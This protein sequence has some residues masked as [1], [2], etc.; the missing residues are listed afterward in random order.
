MPESH[1]IPQNFLARARGR[2]R[3]FTWGGDW[4]FP[5]P[6]EVKHNLY[7][8]FLDGLF[9]T[10]GDNIYI[11]YLAIYILAL[12]ATR[13][14]IGWMS[15]I[16]NL[17][18]ALVLLPGALLVERIG[19]RKTIVVTAGGIVARMAM[20]SLALLPLLLHDRALVWTAIGLAVLRDAGAN[21]AF[22]AWIAMTGDIVPIEGRGRYFGSRNVV[23]G[24]VGMLVIFLAGAWITGAGSP[25]GYQVAFL[26]AFG[27]GSIATYSYWRL[28][29]PHHTP[30]AA[31]LR[32][33]PGE[34]LRD[35]KAHP[36][37]LVLCS[38]MALWNFSLNI[39]GPFFSVRMV[40]D[41][42]FTASMIGTLTIIATVSSLLVQRR[43]GIL[44]DR[45]G[46]RR[47]QMFC[48]LLI[49]F[50][51]LAWVFI[52]R[53]WQVALVNTFSGALWGVFGL[54]S[55]NLLLSFTPEARRARYSAIYQIVILVSLAAG[56][57]CG[58]W[59]IGRWG[60]NGV[61]LCSGVG[62]MLAAILFAL[63]VPAAEAN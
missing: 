7:W 23:Y 14:E 44:A 20:P 16:T 11:T 35:F 36:G 31:R 52:T 12:G 28:R 43:M 10:A 61:F 54:V 56:A 41:L 24:L 60:Y 2:F 13:Q 15:S 63:F 49:P 26:A 59:V 8:F 29:D 40:Q 34:A 48:M 19:R 4:A 45:I 58:A 42:D 22:P 46:P 25:G 37:F 57:A 53:F 39:A 9:A 6:G 5:L 55:F 18:S 47:V 30:P 51:T 33:S 32:L 21:L 62:R 27:L 17:V 1:S 3:Q 50:L 38:V